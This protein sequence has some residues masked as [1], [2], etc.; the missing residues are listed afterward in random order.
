MERPVESFI[1][2]TIPIDT[3][4]VNPSWVDGIYDLITATYKAVIGLMLL[5]IVYFVAGYYNIF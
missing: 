5:T 2:D 1:V 4:V 3:K